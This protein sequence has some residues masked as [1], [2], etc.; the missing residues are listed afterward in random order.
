MLHAESFPFDTAANSD[1]LN[2]PT[3]QQ[4]Q[5]GANILS[6]S[7]HPKD[8]THNPISVNLSGVT[9]NSVSSVLPFSFS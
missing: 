5:L 7:T 9:F 1:G 8:H 2:L 4:D 3:R 6:C